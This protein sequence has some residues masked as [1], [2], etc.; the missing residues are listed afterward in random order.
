MKK[1]YS[2]LF[3]LVALVATV[4][5]AS[6]KGTLDITMMGSEIAKGQATVVDMNETEDGNYTFVL[7]DFSVTIGETVLPLGD[8]VVENVTRIDENGDGTFE[9]A[10]MVED[11]ALPNDPSIAD[12]EKIHAKV[13]IAG[14]ETA[15]GAMDLDIVVGWYVAYP[16]KSETMPIEVKFVGQL[17]PVTVY[18]GKLDI[19][20]MGSEI[21]K[22]QDASVQLKDMGEG[23]YTFVLPNFSVTIG[24]AVLPLGDI[25]VE[26]VTRTDDN[27]DGIFE[28]GGMVED[29]ALPDDPSIAD[30]EKIHAKVEIAGTETSEGAMDLNI[31]VGWYTD[32]PND[33]T[34]TMPIDVKFVGQKKEDIGA[35]VDTV[36]FDGLVYGANG[37]VVVN[38]YEGTVVVYDFAG[39]LVKSAQVA[40]NAEIALTKGLYIVRTGT[41]AAKV[42]VK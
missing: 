36:S 41:K 21:A 23:N 33:L 14:T 5:A 3:M 35:V 17:V 10:G 8:I 16:D 12:E 4:N 1:I 27:G 32:Y 7:P 30:E 26:N 2:I 6:Y 29:L 15:E 19:S 13:E 38:G 31:V 37:V 39:R 11:L 42:V 25:V 22:G 34:Q 24:D 9:I 40:G 18:E 20:M 28:I